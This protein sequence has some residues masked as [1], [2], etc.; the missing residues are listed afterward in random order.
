MVEVLHLVAT[1]QVLEKC[2]NQVESFHI[3][4][5]NLSSN[6]RQKLVARWM[7]CGKDEDKE[8]GKRK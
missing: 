3:Q 7:N 5:R 6:A 4:G 2:C 8:R 1:A